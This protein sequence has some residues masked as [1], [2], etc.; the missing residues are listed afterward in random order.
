[1][2]KQFYPG[3]PRDI[4]EAAQKIHRMLQHEVGARSRPAE[5]QAADAATANSNDPMAGWPMTHAPLSSAHIRR[6]DGYAREGGAFLANRTQAGKS[7]PHRGIDIA[8]SPGTPVYSPIEGT[9]TNVGWAY[10]DGLHGLRSIHVTGPDGHK[11][12]MLYVEPTEG[13]EVGQSVTPNTVLGLSQSLQAAYPVR[14]GGRMT[15]H[16]HFEFFDSSGRRVD[17]TPW[18]DAWRKQID[19]WER[20]GARQRR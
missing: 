16:V 18:V 4:D 10:K 1:M 13:L 14:G 9:I 20:L 19:D 7:Y 6:P 11:I 2:Y 5:A 3:A 17:P 12:K 15:D 8:I